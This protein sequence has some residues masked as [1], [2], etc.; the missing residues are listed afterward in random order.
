MAQIIIIKL[1]QIRFQLIIC[2]NDENLIC[3][4]PLKIICVICDLKCHAM[5]GLFNWYP[6]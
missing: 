2:F 4:N 6:L 3:V 1:S 5:Y